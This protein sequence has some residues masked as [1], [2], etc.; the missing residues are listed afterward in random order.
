M[1]A[2]PEGKQSWR[3]LRT[4]FFLFLSIDQG[5]ASLDVLHAG[6]GQ[7][8]GEL[9]AVAA[10]DEGADEST[11]R[12]RGP[13]AAARHQGDVAEPRN[14]DLEG[15]PH[16]ATVRPA[17]LRDVPSHRQDPASESGARS[18]LAGEDVRVGVEVDDDGA[19]VG[20]EP[21][22]ERSQEGAVGVPELVGEDV[23]AVVGVD[24]DQVVGLAAGE[25][26]FVGVRY[27]EGE[28]PGDLPPQV[29]VGGI[30]EPEGA[31][32]GEVLDGAGGE[33]HRLDRRRH[34]DG[35]DLDDVNDRA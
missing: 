21:A 18:A 9:H 34:H 22:G 19:V 16:A 11:P 3:T 24:G 4:F 5:E 1:D 13:A 2:P 8:Q 14:G 23:V 6:E 29:L 15:H 7:I 31:A 12:R 17:H 25:E 10:G 20:V 32:A 26:E 28:P 27:E 35:V 33:A 30:D